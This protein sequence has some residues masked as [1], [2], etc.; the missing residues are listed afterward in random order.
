VRSAAFVDQDIEKL[1]SGEKHHRTCFCG[2]QFF[3][4]HLIFHSMQQCTETKQIVS[5]DI[6]VFGIA[7]ILASFDP[8][9]NHVEPRPIAATSLTECRIEIV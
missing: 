2:V 3:T 8:C 4:F 6:A 5:N 9:A 1:F 7:V